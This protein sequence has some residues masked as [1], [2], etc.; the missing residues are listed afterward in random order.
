M[1]IGHATASSDTFGHAQELAIVFVGKGQVDIV[2]FFFKIL[3][4]KL[5][6]GS[7][8]LPMHPTC[9][10]HSPAITTVIK[11]ILA[12]D[13]EL[14]STDPK[15]SPTRRTD[16]NVTGLDLPLRFIRFPSSMR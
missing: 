9:I 8:Q 6:W 4:G 5:R 13:F 12:I 7:V 3:A 1:F 10:K 2:V 11:P 14:I 15:E 16:A